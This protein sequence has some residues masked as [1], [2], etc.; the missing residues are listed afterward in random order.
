MHYRIVRAGLSCSRGSSDEDET[1]SDQTDDDETDDTNTKIKISRDA[2]R[3]MRKLVLVCN[4]SDSY[5]TCSTVTFLQGDVLWGFDDSISW[6][7]DFMLFSAERYLQ[8]N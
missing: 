2:K 3:W 5:E 6:Q 8:H 7:M 1:D 4:K